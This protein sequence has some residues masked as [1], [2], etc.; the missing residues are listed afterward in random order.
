M[1]KAEQEAE[2]IAEQFGQ[3]CA[4]IHVEGI[5]DEINEMDWEFSTRIAALRLYYWDEVLT[6]LKDK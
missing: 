2:R 1:T 5:M 4:I 3:N 6:I